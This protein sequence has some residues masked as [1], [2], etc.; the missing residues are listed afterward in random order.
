ML[1][2]V[3]RIRQFLTGQGGKT[4]WPNWYAPSGVK[5]EIDRLL[6]FAHRELPD[7]EQ[8]IA[9]LAVT[10]RDPSVWLTTLP[11]RDDMSTESIALLKAMH[12]RKRSE[13]RRQQ[14]TLKKNREKSRLECKYARWLKTLVGKQRIPFDM[15][16]LI[17]L[18]GTTESDSL[19]IHDILTEWFGKWF[20]LDRDQTGTLHDDQRWSDFLNDRSVFD[21][22]LKDTT[23]ADWVKDGLWT[24]MQLTASNLLPEA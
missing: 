21:D 12:G 3:I 17:L 19:K 2:T 11:T 14:T 9:V 20:A 1:R 13:K 8:R 18:D 22:L 24:S 16:K 7:A 4:K 15:D 6:S 5:N 23:V 10:G